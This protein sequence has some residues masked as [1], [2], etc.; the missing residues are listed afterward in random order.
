MGGKILVENWVLV[1]GVG[2]CLYLFHI[3]ENKSNARIEIV[4]FIGFVMCLS[5]HT[6]LETDKRHAAFEEHYQVEYEELIVRP[7]SDGFYEVY[8][9]NGK[10]FIFYNEKE[11][12]LQLLNREYLKYGGLIATNNR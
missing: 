11:E 12:K 8:V 7:L 1:L 3:F 6:A 4:A 10:E 5:L 9:D 2:L